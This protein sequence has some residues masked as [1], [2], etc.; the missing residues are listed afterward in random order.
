MAAEHDE[1]RAMRVGLLLFSIY[2]FFYALFVYMSAFH[3]DIMARHGGA[4]VNVAVWFGFT[5][6]V[7]PP[8]LALLYLW[9]C[10]ARPH[11]GAPK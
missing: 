9:L 4:S 2:L 6:I 7:S 5:L 3:L 10:R 11:G 8:L 1:R